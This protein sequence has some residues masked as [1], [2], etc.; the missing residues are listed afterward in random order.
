MSTLSVAEPRAAS[1]QLVRNIAAIAFTRGGSILLD[2]IAYVL[3]AR[4]LGPVAYGHYL[5]FMALVILLDT[6]ADL[7]V[8]D[9][10]VRETSKH[11]A[12]TNTWLTVSTVLRFLLACAAFVV[13]ATYVILG[14]SSFPPDL[15]TGAWIAAV[16]LPIGALRM[17]IAVFRAHLRLEYELAATLISRGAN[18]ILIFVLISRGA[19]VAYFFA[20]AAFSRAVWGIL[21][22]V[23]A[24]TALGLTFAWKHFD[25]RAFRK[26]V[27]ESWPMG[28][29]GIFVVLQL[30]GDILLVSRLLD[31]HAAGVY[32]VVANLPEYFLYLSVIVTT[33]VLP[34]LSRLYA[35]G[36]H[37]RFQ[38]LYQALFDFLMMAIIPVAVIVF[39]M[40]QTVVTAFFGAEYADAA[41]VLPLLMASIVLMWISHV[42]AIAAVAT[43]LQGSFAWIQTTCVAVFALMNIFL[44]PAWGI[45]GAATARVVGTLIAPVLTYGVV[46]KRAHFSL[47]TSTLWRVALAAAAMGSV[48]VVL[49]RFSS[50][51]AIAAGAFTY[52]ATLT[53]AGFPD[54]RILRER[55]DEPYG[56]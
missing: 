20:V 51:L 23:F 9:I 24:R 34:L 32:G 49:L 2:G 18:L 8:F 10:A 19:G 1:L 17:P 52:L 6:A 46:V 37:P 38:A 53:V 47:H 30:R 50:I 5:G 25:A 36:D 22:W 27:W 12:E 39:V 29:S 33:P 15:M 7:T 44:V 54:F 21:S 26:L 3:V 11:P 43:G 13:Y 48:M 16:I 56:S 35:A 4:Y 42:T 14:R 41:S 28:L 40:P 55:G 45:V 31:A